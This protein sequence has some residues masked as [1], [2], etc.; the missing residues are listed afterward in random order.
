[1]KRNLTAHRFL[2]S[3]SYAREKK[4]MYNRKRGETWCYIFI[5]S[6]QR[7]KSSDFRTI[8]RRKLIKAVIIAASL[9]SPNS[10]A[11]AGIFPGRFSLAID[12][13][14]RFCRRQKNSPWTSKLWNP[15]SRYISF[16]FF[17]LPRIAINHARN[18]QKNKRLEIEGHLLFA[19]G[20]N[21][22]L[23]IIKKILRFEGRP[24]LNPDEERPDSTEISGVSL[25]PQSS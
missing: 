8:F 6:L 23:F 1:M 10:P 16:D 3:S 15:R 13:Y 19:F 5:F 21:L 12:F 11:S 20:I 4:Y 22:F 2:N 17:S 25:D 24:W 7:T 18:C 9:Q 14:F